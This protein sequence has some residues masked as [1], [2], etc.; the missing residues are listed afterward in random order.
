M[1]LSV[2]AI[3]LSWLLGSI[4][5][6]YIVTRLSLGTDIR[7]LGSG[8]SGATNVYR[9]LG[10]KYA[11]AVFLF[12]FLKGFLPVLFILRSGLPFSLRPADLAVVSGSAA[13]I[14]HVFPVFI[15]WK[16]GKGVA[17]GAGVLTALYPP[18]FPACLAVFAAVLLLS[19]TMSLASIVTAL[20]VPVWYVTL[21]AL[22]HKAPEFSMTLFT[23]LI[24]AAVIFTH[25]KNIIKIAK[26]NENKLY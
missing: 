3:V 8:N 1:V 6:A 16:G 5:S 21:S 7:T 24:A 4:P 13:F 25:V 12:D 26:G 10:F 19:R 14:G 2:S 18:L 15:G 17:T 23:V 22:T 20:S 9:I 11:A